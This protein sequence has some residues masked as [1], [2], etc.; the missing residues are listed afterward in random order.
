MVDLEKTCLLNFS[1]YRHEETWYVGMKKW[2]PPEQNTF[3]MVD[4]GKIVFL[5]FSSYHDEKSYV[6]M[7]KWC[8]PEQNTFEI[9]DF[10]HL[11]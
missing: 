9:V 5:N 3:E 6:E 11:L 4:L 7:K 2:C 1:S 8:P 10:F